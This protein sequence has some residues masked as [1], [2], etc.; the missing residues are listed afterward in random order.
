MALDQRLGVLLGDGLD[1]HAALGGDHRQQLLLAAVEDHRGVVLRR[2]VR[3]ALDP[4][5]VDAEGPLA[6]RPTNVHA[7]DRVCVCARLLGVLGD[8]DPARLAAAADQDL[9]LDRARVAD[10]LRGGNRLL[11]GRSD[12]AARH[13]DA[14]LGEQLLALVLEEVHVEARRAG[15]GGS[16]SEN[17]KRGAARSPDSHNMP[18]SPCPSPLSKP[19]NG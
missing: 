12:L 2:D 6:A 18:R 16:L 15:A 3:A 14:V 1:V 19:S 4:D 8:L 10:P 13:G 11:D 17:A 9:G 7:E 5:L